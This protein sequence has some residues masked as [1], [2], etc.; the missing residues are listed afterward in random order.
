[1]KVRLACSFRSR[2]RGLLGKD[3][4]D[5]ALLLAPCRSIH[6]HGMR[7]SIDV[8]FLSEEGTVLEAHRGVPPGRRLGNRSAVAVLE[9]FASADSWFDESGAKVEIDS[10]DGRW[11]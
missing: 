8:A 1:M 9:R 5:G 4:L 2:L 7:R 10:M 11:L 3:E 6:T